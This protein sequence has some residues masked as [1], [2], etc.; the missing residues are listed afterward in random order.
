MQTIPTTTERWRRH[1]GKIALGTLAAALAAW[2]LYV[3]RGDLNR[4]TLVAYG[5]GIHAPWF[6]AAFLILP[7]AGFPLS[8]FLFLAGVRFG[9]H[10]GMAVAG[11]VMLFHH[12]AAFRLAHGFFRD[13]V[14]ARLERAGYGIPP[15]DPKHRIWF[16][17]L[18]AALHGPPYAVKLYLLALTDVPFRIYFWIGA[19]IYI[20]FCVIPVGAGSAVMDFNPTWLYILVG[21]TMLL[22]LGG[23]WLRHRFGKAFHKSE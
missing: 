14:R 21:V 7:L 3:H 1:R 8:I 18:F 22:L 5:K 23:Y 6:I 17:A 2:F 9:M 11:G 10:A 4:E 12:F 20:A 13:P 15:I 19:P 16:T